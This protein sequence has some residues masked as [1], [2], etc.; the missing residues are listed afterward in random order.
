M[1]ATIVG[2][3]II[4]LSPYLLCGSMK[5]RGRRSNIFQNLLDSFSDICEVI[6]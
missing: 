6:Y 3:E 2:S 5:V 4:S 1:V